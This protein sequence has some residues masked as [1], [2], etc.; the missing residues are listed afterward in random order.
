MKI[1]ELKTTLIRCKRCNDSIE[2]NSWN[3]KYCLPCYKIVYSKGKTYKYSGFKKTHQKTKT[4]SQSTIYRR[5]RL[6]KQQ[7]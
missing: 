1:P 6:W 2:K 7:K 3:H 5:K 4:I